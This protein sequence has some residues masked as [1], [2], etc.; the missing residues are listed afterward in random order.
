MDP[1]TIPPNI[2]YQC[3]L[4]A[5]GLIVELFARCNGD[6]PALEILIQAI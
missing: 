4:E 2:W 3:S 6:W 1:T 5:E